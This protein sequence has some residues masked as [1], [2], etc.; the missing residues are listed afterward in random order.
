VTQFSTLNGRSKPSLERREGKHFMQES[1][2]DLASL[3]SCVTHE[4]GSRNPVI[5]TRLETA[6][7]LRHFL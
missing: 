3:I 1:I 7:F 6:V 2:A 4:I 5:P